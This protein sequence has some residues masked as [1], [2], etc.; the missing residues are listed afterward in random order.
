LYANFVVSGFDV[1]DSESKPEGG[2]EIGKE[3]GDADGEE[4]GVN[5]SWEGKTKLE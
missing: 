5:S 1:D 2:S 4:E 3:A